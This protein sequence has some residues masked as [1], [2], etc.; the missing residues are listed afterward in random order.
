M[1]FNASISIFPERPM[2]GKWRPV[3]TSSL[4]TIPAHL[5]LH[6]EVLGSQL[7]KGLSAGER[8]FLSFKRASC[9][10]DKER[11]R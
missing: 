7:S 1:S 8:E 5:S 6:G 4:Q 2:L 9:S 11:E 3:M 10:C